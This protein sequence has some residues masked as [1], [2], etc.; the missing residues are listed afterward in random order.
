MNYK[1]ILLIILF[2]LSAL[3]VSH[4]IKVE[5]D[6]YKRLQYDRSLDIAEGLQR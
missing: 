2:I 6:N 4:C 1:T 5:C 3:Y